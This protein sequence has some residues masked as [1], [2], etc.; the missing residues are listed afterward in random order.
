MERIK[1]I[2]SGFVICLLPRGV[3]HKLIPPFWYPYP[4]FLHVND[5]IDIIIPR[6]RDTGEI[7][8]RNTTNTPE[9]SLI[10]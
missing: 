1:D 2:P 9:K 10:L 8:D 7:V 6:K 3:P 4:I 5:R